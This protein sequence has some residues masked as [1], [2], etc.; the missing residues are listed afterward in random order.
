MGYKERSGDLRAMG[1]SLAEA[2]CAL[3]RLRLLLYSFPGTAITDN[4]KL[5]SV[6][7]RKFILSLLWSSE[8]RNQG[9][10]RCCGLGACVSPKIHML[11]LT[12]HMT[13]LGGGPWGDDSLT[14]GEPPRVGL[15]AF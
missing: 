5:D 9:I 3:G 6:R 13:V 11:K 7:Q 15:M 4:P 8:V 10:G 1:R 2:R 14:R 12:P